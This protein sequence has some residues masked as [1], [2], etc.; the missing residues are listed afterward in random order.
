MHCKF[1]TIKWIK[2]H[3]LPAVKTKAVLS[4]SLSLIFAFYMVLRV[5]H[6]KKA[7]TNFNINKT[8]LANFIT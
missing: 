7:A 6:R 2:I 3:E 5:A 8:K 1:S 4:L